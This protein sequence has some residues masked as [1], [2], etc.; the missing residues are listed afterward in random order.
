MSTSDVIQVMIVDDHGMVRRGLST[1]L[2]V[3]ADLEL[4]GEASNGQEA[5]NNVVKH[6]DATQIQIDLLCATS[7]ASIDRHPK[8]RVELRVCDDGQGFDPN[9]VS[10]DRLGLG[11]I[12][13]RAQAIGATPQIESQPGCG[14]QLVVVWKEDE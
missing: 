10:P 14:T 9:S 8:K 6:A 5:L 11:I 4:V 12:R 7:P 13:E 3:K 1:I 2:K